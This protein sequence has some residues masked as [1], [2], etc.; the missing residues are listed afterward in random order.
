MYISSASFA[1]PGGFYTQMLLSFSHCIFNNLQDEK[2]IWREKEISKPEGDGSE[3]ED[4]I[5]PFKRRH[6]SGVFL[7]L[8]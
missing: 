3:E 8:D 2:A 5:G 7:L 1:A 4:I 6:G